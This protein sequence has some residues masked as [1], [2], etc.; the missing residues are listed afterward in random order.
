MIRAL[1]APGVPIKINNTSVPGLGFMNITA[2]SHSTSSPG[3]MDL[4][5][6]FIF[7]NLCDKSNVLWDRQCK[8]EHIAHLDFRAE[9]LSSIPDG[10][11]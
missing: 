2:W 3:S 5:V 9:L 4:I 11:L 7:N 10:H 6:S 1:K 8:A